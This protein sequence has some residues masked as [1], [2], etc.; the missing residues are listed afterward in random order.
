[1]SE[2][3]TTIRILYYDV[4]LQSFQSLPCKSHGPFGPGLGAAPRLEDHAADAAK[5]VDANLGGLKAATVAGQVAW[6]PTDSPTNVLGI[7]GM[8]WEKFGAVLGF[9]SL[10]N[11]IVI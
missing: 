5:A 1:M 2:F 7:L 9:I 3:N 4:S 10:H 11:S 8:F 6:L